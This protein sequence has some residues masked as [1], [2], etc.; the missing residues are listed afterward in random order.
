[1]KSIFGSAFILISLCVFAITS[2]Q[3]AVAQSAGRYVS[4]SYNDPVCPG[5]PDAGIAPD[6]ASCYSFTIDSAR[7]T[8]LGGQTGYS[9][10]SCVGIPIPS[11]GPTPAPAPA[12]PPRIQSS[13]TYSATPSAP[14]EADT[15]Q[16]TTP[17][18][19]HGRGKISVVACNKTGQKIF[20]AFIYYQTNLRWVN[21]GW[22]NVLNGH[23]EQLFQTNNATFYLYAEDANNHQWAGDHKDCAV[24]PDA[25]TIFEDEL[26]HNVCPR[27]AALDPFFVAH[28]YN[29]G[30]FTQNFIRV[31]GASQKK[32]RSTHRKA[33]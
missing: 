13:P 5:I 2:S 6:R 22:V 23:C 10:S 30:R 27:T 17:R 29:N 33:R 1:M 9:S 11:A 12:P 3:T 18:P 20:V 32:H 25:F 28:A 4:G 7:C 31:V 24:H 8:S 15:G 21:R 16:L 19:D 26:D 14:T